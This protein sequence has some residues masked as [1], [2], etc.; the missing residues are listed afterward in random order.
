MRYYSEVGI[1][2]ERVAVRS[3]GDPQEEVEGWKYVECDNQPL[4]RKWNTGLQSFTDVDAVMIV[5]SDDFIPL[6]YVE[7][8]IERIKKG[9]DVVQGKGL[10]IHQDGKLHWCYPGAPGA[11]RVISRRILERA[12]W[13]LWEDGME[14]FLDSSAQTVLQKCRARR[15][16]LENAPILDVKTD[17]NLWRLNGEYLNDG[18]RDRIKFATVRE[19]ELDE[20]RGHFP[21]WVIESLC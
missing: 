9:A 12:D 11:G 18:E 19:A 6:S 4:G 21:D 7:T 8:A 2:S 5:G 16:R 10:Y 13:R 3:P 20:L 14:R 17:V 15:I 1:G